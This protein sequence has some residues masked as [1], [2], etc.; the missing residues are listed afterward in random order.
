MGKGEDTSAGFPARLKQAIGGSSVSAFARECGLGESL[1][2]S[3]LGGSAPGLDK[4]AAI[5]R[6]A[7]VDLWWLATGEGSAGP[8]RQGLAEPPAPYEDDLVAVPHVDLA[9]ARG[10]DGLDAANRG[11]GV[12]A[13]RRDWVRATLGVDADSLVL[14]T[15]AGD[16][17]AP[18]I[19]DGDLM[20]VE[21]GADRLR[22]DGLYVVAAGDRWTVR[23]LQ[24]L[25][26]GSVAV[27]PDNPAF[28]EEVVAA[29][30]DDRLKIAGRVRWI[31]RIA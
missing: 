2:R 23:R 21:T 26:D 5:A 13:L 28:A 25:T 14:V 20:L 8:A 17:M 16:A 18:A 27:R 9:A 19:R 4:A 15:G 29:E 30:D 31:A 12:M 10:A 3:Y 6:A 22:E 1:L 24:R 7:G 11:T